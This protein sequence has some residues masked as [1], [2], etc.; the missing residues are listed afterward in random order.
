MNSPL[1]AGLTFLAVA[2]L[3]TGCSTNKPCCSSSDAKSGWVTLFDGKSTEAFRGFKRDSFP[4]ES[5]KVEDGVL[6]TIPGN[7]TDVITR[8]EYESFELTL[9]WKISPGGNSGVMYH[10]SE[11]FNTAWQTGPEMQVL[12]DSKHKDGGNPKTSAGA[13]Y[14]LIAPTNKVVKPAGEWNQVRLLVNKNHVEHWLNGRKVVQYEL[15]SPE[16]EKLIAESKFAKMPRFA[17]EKL[18]HIALQHHHDE[19]WYRNIKIRRL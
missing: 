7:G 2:F 12:D 11:A 18:G 5:W 8:D 6:K 9:E 16:L 1:K 15:N 10:V 14:A 3:A 17:K 4:K 13:L 19:V